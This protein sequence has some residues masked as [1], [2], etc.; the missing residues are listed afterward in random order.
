MGADEFGRL[1]AGKGQL[2]HLAGDLTLD[3][4]RTYEIVFAVCHPDDEALWIGGLL[5]ELARLPFIRAHVVCL[6]GKDPHSPR[7]QEF[8]A[9][10]KAAGYSSGVVLGGPLRPAPEPLPDTSRTLAQGLEQLA[11]KR[12]GIDL[13]VTHSPYGDEHKHP[14]HVQTHRELKSWCEAEGVPFG[15]FSCIPIPSVPHMPLLTELR[16]R[17]SLHLL[18]LCQCTANPDANRRRDLRG[19]SSHRDHSKYFIQFLTDPVAKAKMLACYPSI[20]LAQHEQG[21]AMF[22][23]ACEALYLADDRA[24]APWRAIIDAL[25]IPGAPELMKKDAA[26]S[27]NLLVRA[28]RKLARALGSGRTS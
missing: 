18:N 12:N 28:G 8:D 27:P 6:S 1:S 26:S 15:F 9:A 14:H 4:A 25:D 7:M 13:L 22:T 11:I 5:C 23:S 3:S 10:Q 17:G 2:R 21:Y 24:L 19:A 16:R 20:G